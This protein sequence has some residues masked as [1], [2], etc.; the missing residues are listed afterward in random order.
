[1]EH[2]DFIPKKTISIALMPELDDEFTPFLAGNA[3]MVND[4]LLKEDCFTS[5]IIKKF[6]AKISDKGLIFLP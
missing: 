4:R 1:M 2:P 6:E 5:R 3:I